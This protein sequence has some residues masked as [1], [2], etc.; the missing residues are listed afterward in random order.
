MAEWDSPGIPNP[1]GMEPGGDRVDREEPTSTGLLS[2]TV[3]LEFE[4]RWGGVCW[5]LVVVGMVERT[6]LASGWCLSMT[7]AQHESVSSL[8]VV[9]R[10][11]TGR[12]YGPLERR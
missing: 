11:V 4:D 5:R 10:W 9:A 12:D 1:A 2:T 3:S 6:V 7:D 8:G